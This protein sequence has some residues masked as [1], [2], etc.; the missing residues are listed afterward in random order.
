MTAL[1]LTPLKMVFQLIEIS[2]SGKEARVWDA[3]SWGVIL[4]YDKP[5]L[6]MD[7]IVDVTKKVKARTDICG[8]V[9]I[10]DQVSDE[11]LKATELLTL[12]G[13]SF[14]LLRR[15]DGELLLR[16]GSLRRAVK[17]VAPHTK[18][19]G[20]PSNLVRGPD[21]GYSVTNVAN[22][23]GLTRAGVW[24]Y[25]HSYGFKSTITRTQLDSLLQD[26]LEAIRE[27]IRRLEEKHGVPA[28]KIPDLPFIAQP[29]VLARDDLI[30]EDDL[31][32]DNPE[33]VRALFN[34]TPVAFTI[35]R[36]GPRLVFKVVEE[37][38]ELELNFG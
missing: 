17:L 4:I 34:L 38:S 19:M 23:L 37:E 5:E 8:A 26:K 18:T 22:Y 16:S 15:V 32:R 10:S 7:V 9:F 25:F 12:E 14:F 36:H 3:H 29:E 21:D 30:S 35:M 20:R 11:F 24:K 31:E 13:I 2:P 33:T 27:R 28:F 1:D 6:L